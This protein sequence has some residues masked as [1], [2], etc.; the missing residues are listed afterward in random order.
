MDALK[1]L[2]VDE[3]LI[4]C[5][6][7][8]AG[9]N[10]LGCIATLSGR[11]VHSCQFVFLSS[12][13]AVMTAWGESQGVPSDSII[14]LMGDPYG[15]LTEKLGME[16]QHLGPKEKGLINRCKRFALYSVDGIVK[17]VRVA[18][19]ENDPAGDDFPDDTLAEAMID[20]IKAFGS[21]KE[22]L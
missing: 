3:V 8:G 20:A 16:L 2:G 9:E 15:E 21:S 12:S 17:I 6:N 1:E 4:Y 22:E 19:R 13:D 18:E 10:F 5:V 14:K 11:N 7:D